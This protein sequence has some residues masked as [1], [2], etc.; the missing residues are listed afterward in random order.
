GIAKQVLSALEY[1]HERKVLHRDVKPGNILVS[2][3]GGV[4]VVDFGL[5]KRLVDAAFTQQTSTGTPGTPLFMAPE[6]LGGG[7]A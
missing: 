3:D 6:L 1:A 5:A 2:D 4:K 7:Q